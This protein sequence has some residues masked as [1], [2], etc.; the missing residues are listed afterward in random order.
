MA[1]EQHFFAYTRLYWMCT[2]GEGVEWLGE[3][4]ERT[5]A[6]GVGCLRRG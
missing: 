2:Y 5:G 1:L 3:Q 6:S 4:A